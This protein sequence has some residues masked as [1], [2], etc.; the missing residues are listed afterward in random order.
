[1]KDEKIVNRYSIR[2]ANQDDCELLARFCAD[3]ADLV[4]LRKTWL[5]EKMQEGLTILIASSLPGSPTTINDPETTNNR[6]RIIGIL[7][8]AP[9]AISPYPVEQNKDLI[10]LHCLWVI[11]E[12]KEQG[13]GKAL[14]QELISRAR[15]IGKRGIAVVCYYGERYSYSH[16]PLFFFE[17]FGFYRCD[18]DGLRQLAYLALKPGV[19]PH[20]LALSTST[21][22]ANSLPELII[23]WH[24]QCPVSLWAAWEIEEKIRDNKQVQL[25]IINSAEQKNQGMI[26]GIRFNG[27]P[28]YDG[29][30]LWSAVKSLM[31]KNGLLSA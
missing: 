3:T 11:P 20:L 31:I 18:S 10:I 2:E 30:V 4:E 15:A 25:S 19:A 23:Y 17:K 14:M 22:E 13:A 6:S 12:C 26:M 21:H 27:K 24:P 1:M 28:V 8:Y 9:S 5:K 29:L 16:M 7:E